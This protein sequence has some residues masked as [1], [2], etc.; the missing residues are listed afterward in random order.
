MNSDKIELRR[1][2]KRLQEVRAYL[3]VAAIGRRKYIP[4]TFD[5]MMVDFGLAAER[6]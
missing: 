6:K 5:G 2:R 1:F 4:T 3:K